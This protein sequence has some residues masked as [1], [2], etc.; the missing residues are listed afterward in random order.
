MFVAAARVFYALYENRGKSVV[1]QGEFQ[2]WQDNDAGF[3]RPPSISESSDGPR[4]M[5]D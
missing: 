5:D 2:Y 4:V 3:D 1:A